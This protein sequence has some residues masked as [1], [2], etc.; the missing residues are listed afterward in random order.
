MKR[1]VK[2][3]FSIIFCISMLCSGGMMLASADE[4]PEA[5]LTFTISGGKAEITGLKNAADVTVVEIPSE[6]DGAVVTGIG[7]NA[8]FDV[9]NIIEVILPE[10]IEYIG[11]KAFARCF[12]LK[13]I[14]FPDG[15]ER[16]EEE[17]FCDANS[18]LEAMLPD[19]VTYL[20]DRAFEYC[21]WL[22]KARIP[23]GFE[24]IGNYVFHS[25]STLKSIELPDKLVA[26]GDYAFARCGM[27]RSVDLPGTLKSIGAYAFDGCGDI[28]KF[29]IPSGVTFFGEGAFTSC[30]FRSFEIPSSVKEIGKACFKDCNYLEKITIPK[31]ITAIPESAFYGC[32]RMTEVVLPSTVTRIE[33][34]AFG[35]CNMLTS[36]PVT[37]NVTYIGDSAYSGSDKMTEITIPASVTEIGKNAFYG[38]GYYK[39]QMNWEGGCLYIGNALIKLYESFDG[40]TIKKGTV[41][42]ANN[43]GEGLNR[44]FMKLTIPSGVKYIGENAFSGSFTSFGINI[45]ASV[46]KIGRNAF[47]FTRISAFN[48]DSGNKYYCSDSAGALFNKSKTELI[49]FPSENKLTSY[50][51]PSTV[52]VICDDAFR[53][54]DY[55]SSVTLPSGLELIGNC[56]FD[57]CRAL[58]SV[59]IP[60]RVREIGYNAFAGCIALTEVTLPEGLEKL[61]GGAFFDCAK[62][63]E[64]TL[65]ASLEEMGDFVLDFCSS[66]QKV[67]VLNPN[68][69][70]LS[71]LP[72]D[73]TAAV[74]SYS[75]SGA[76]E[77]AESNNVTFVSLGVAPVLRVKTTEKSFGLGDDMFI[78]IPGAKV[79]DLTS[80]LGAAVV[81]TDKDGNTV[82]KDSVIRSG[83]KITLKFKNGKIADERTVVVPGD[84]DGDGAISA[85]DSRT[86]LR[87]AVGLDNLN[88]WQKVASDVS[89]PEKNQ[90]TSSDA[91]D[92]LRA[93]VGLEKADNWFLQLKGPEK[94]IAA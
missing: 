74:H 47:N 37:N 89:E 58:S 79:S 11:E 33:K 1:T 92:I 77:Y 59:T 18:L 57:G 8:F 38:T 51:L 26:I 7:A 54:N 55:L 69:E 78:V 85:N 43:A 34:S 56:A 17:A 70:F 31:G 75:N 15:L 73:S 6:I 86:A 81:V 16:I 27:L 87:A 40:S 25:C 29:D 90:I 61:G 3:I 45:P 42:I 84:N 72:W 36:N 80:T 65:P 83:I 20:G 23:S 35:S 22:Q 66:L 62:L 28:E 76:R 5:D 64:L 88:F 10:T 60:S 67:T 24:K 46:V 50:K 2:L 53:V 19:S 91:R 82:S 4:A 68:L 9:Q 49:R 41:I 32:E 13:K 30:E 48:V 21:S 44:V 93:A 52:K 63:K 39:N 14:N 94:D 71:L 12:D